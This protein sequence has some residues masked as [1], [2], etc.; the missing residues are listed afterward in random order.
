M[1]PFSTL[2]DP[3]RNFSEDKEVLKARN[4]LGFRLKLKKIMKVVNVEIETIKKVEEEIDK[5]IKD[6]KKRAALE[7]NE[8][9]LIFQI[10]V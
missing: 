5:K 8:I 1:T 2:L 7:E 4:S 3:K 9:I 10:K 6:S